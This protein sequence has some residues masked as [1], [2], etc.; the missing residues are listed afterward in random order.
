MAIKKLADRKSYD[1]SPITQIWERE[2]IS[3]SGEGSFTIY[4]KGNQVEVNGSSYNI[5]DKTKLRALIRDLNL[6]LKKF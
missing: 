2:T 5:K 4:K 3:G 6:A 1:S